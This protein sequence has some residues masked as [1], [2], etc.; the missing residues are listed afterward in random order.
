MFQNS[1]FTSLFWACTVFCTPASISPSFNSH[2]CKEIKKET[3]RWNRGEEARKRQWGQ[4]DFHFPCWLQTFNEQENEYELWSGKLG[5]LAAQ[6]SVPPGSANRR[7][8]IKA[9]KLYGTWRSCWIACTY[10]PYCSWAWHL[11]SSGGWARSYGS[12]PDTEHQSVN[13]VIS[14]TSSESSYEAMASLMNVSTKYREWGRLR[15]LNLVLSVFQVSLFSAWG[16][17]RG[18]I[19]IKPLKACRAIFLVSWSP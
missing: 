2:G 7:Q 1:K 11:V 19:W 8:K 16:E 3:E 14:V 12:S 9:E 6:N 5:A 15:C 18:D 4:H 10:R 17:H 13:P